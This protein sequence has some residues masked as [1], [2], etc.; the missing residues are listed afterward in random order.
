V[1]PLK[2]GSLSDFLAA[3]RTFLAWIR[4]GLALAGFGF[5]IARF[6]LFLR[7]M[8]YDAGLAA[9]GTRGS[10]AIGAIIVFG[11]ALAL[12]WSAWSYTRLVGQ[13]KRGE[14]ESPP[15]TA[16]AVVMAL[17]MAALGVALAIH[18]LTFNAAARQPG[19]EPHMLSENGVVTIPSHHPVDTTVQKIEE[20]LSAKGIKLFAIVDHSGEA[21]TAGFQM[22]PC[23]LLIFGNPA[24]GTPLM[25]ASPSAALDLPLK[26]LVWEKADGT[27]WLSYND[28]GY[29]QHRHALP[30]S[31]MRNIAVIDALAAK[32]AE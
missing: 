2:K 9:S 5:V 10:P 19:E 17:L 14:T 31:L 7:E 16:F 20:I 30:D 18:L 32:A 12:V 29:L 6:G 8:R 3:E 11:G 22:R 27:T 4:T 26:I 23:K 1:Y 13:L 15:G 28:S 25:L 21:G 24:A